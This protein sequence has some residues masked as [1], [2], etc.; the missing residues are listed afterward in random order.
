MNSFLWT[1]NKDEEDRIDFD[2]EF[3][4][5]IAERVLAAYAAT[6]G[7]TELPDPY[8]LPSLKRSD[9]YTRDK[10]ALMLPC[11][12]HWG[13]MLQVEYLGRFI[14]FAV[15][16]F[17]N[18]RNYAKFRIFARKGRRR[19]WLRQEQRVINRWINWMKAKDDAV[20]LASTGGSTQYTQAE[21]MAHV[22]RRARRFRHTRRSELFV[23]LK[24]ARQRDTDKK[25]LPLDHTRLLLQ[26]HRGHEDTAK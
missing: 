11:W 13:T 14:R 22:V 16:A 6:T 18:L 3:D 15:R 8:S 5:P 1:K 25:D 7:L 4:T 19:Y 21:I 24:Q 12:Q 9:D 17:R 10:I 2:D 23:E 26:A 20:V